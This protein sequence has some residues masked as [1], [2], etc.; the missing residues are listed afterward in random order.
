MT[1]RYNY[2][3]IK[4]F[5]ENE[6]GLPQFTKNGEVVRVDDDEY[7]FILHD[8]A[9]FDGNADEMYDAYLFSR[10]IIKTLKFATEM[11][12]AEIE[13]VKQHLNKTLERDWRKVYAYYDCCMKLLK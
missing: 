11:S 1:K 13:Y 4:R 8:L 12:N 5:C 10:L 9:T 2:E 3:E 7:G 6:S